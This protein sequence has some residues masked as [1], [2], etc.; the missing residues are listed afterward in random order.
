[1]QADTPFV[2]DMLKYGHVKSNT[3]EQRRRSFES[4][5]GS[6]APNLVQNATPTPQT[7]SLSLVNE[8][9]STPFVFL[10]VKFGDLTVSSPV[11][12]GAMHNFLAASF[13]P[14]LRGSPSLVLIVPCQFQVSLADGN[15]VQAAQLATLAPEVVDDQG[16]IV[17]GM[18]AL[19]FYILDTPLA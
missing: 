11:D 9:T 5:G 1:M 15:V 8:Q 13:L 14:K 3:A 17:P 10:P 12:S 4:L 18:P 19:E 6:N 16:V 7:G 2:P